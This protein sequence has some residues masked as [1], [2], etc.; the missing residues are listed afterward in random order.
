MKNHMKDV[1]ELLSVELN[2]E[3]EIVRIAGDNN[4]YFARLTINGIEVRD[5]RKVRYIGIEDFL[6]TQ[7]LIGR[8]Y[9]IKHFPYKPKYRESYWYVT[10]NGDI[11]VDTWSSY[12]FDLIFYKIGNCY[13]SEEEARKHIEKWKKFYESDELLD[14]E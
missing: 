7:L 10:K 1:A 6:L 5:E 9:D 3:F 11:E 12:S 14:V 2:E 8:D 13:K 4:K